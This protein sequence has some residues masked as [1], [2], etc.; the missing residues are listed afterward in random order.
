MKKHVYRAKK[1]LKQAVCLDILDCTCNS[2]Q[3][4]KLLITDIIGKLGRNI[5]MQTT[6]Q[7]RQ[8]RG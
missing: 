2:N 1:A 7:C 4:I 5:I 6:L 3:F 8:Y